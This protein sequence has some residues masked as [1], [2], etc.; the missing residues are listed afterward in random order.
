MYPHLSVVWTCIHGSQYLTIYTHPNKAQNTH[1]KL[2][3]ASGAAV[4]HHAHLAD[5][6]DAHASS[7]ETVEN[8]VNHLYLAVVVA[9]A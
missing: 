6:I 2:T 5:L 3:K 1:A 8:L 4:Y 7:S 9:C